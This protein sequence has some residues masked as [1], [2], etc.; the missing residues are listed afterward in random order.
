MRRERHITD[1]DGLRRGTFVVVVLMMLLCFLFGGCKDDAPA[2]ADGTGLTK[3]NFGVG[4]GSQWT[5]RYTY[6]LGPHPPLP[7]ISENRTGRRVWELQTRTIYLDSITSMV[8]VQ[9]IDTV[10][11]REYAGGAVVHDTT[12]VQTS[13]AQF[14]VGVYSDSIKTTW[15]MTMRITNAVPGTIT[16][17]L[18]A[19]GD[20]LKIDGTGYDYSTSWYVQGIGLVKYAAGHTSPQSGFAESLDLISA[21]LR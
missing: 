6:T 12:F 3:L 7:G 9:G 17:T 11:Q 2:S 19:T 18:P 21:S 20:T 16:R 5:Y 4:I 14:T 8:A 1:Q 13:T 10:R 15:M